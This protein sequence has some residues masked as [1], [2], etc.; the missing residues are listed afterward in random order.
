M[1]ALTLDH[2]VPQPLRAA[3]GDD[4]AF[5]LSPAC[6]VV[7]CNPS[8]FVVRKGQTILPVT[9][10]DQGDHVPVCYCFGFKRGDLRQDL[11]ERGRT[12]IPERIKKGIAEGRCACERKNPQGAC[13]LGNVAN[14]IKAIQ[15]E[16]N[17][18]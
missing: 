12:A 7:Y 18:V 11:A 2:H 17:R 3:L 8:G 16:T 9:I 1:T 5:C 6:E 4:A 15:A 10:K 13:C 14:S